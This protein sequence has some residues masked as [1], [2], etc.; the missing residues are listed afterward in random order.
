MR[1]ILASSFFGSAIEFYDFLLFATAA[2]VVFPTVFFPNT[3]PTVA[4]FASFGTLA[5][6]Y[7]ARPLGGV[8]FGH[9]GD[10]VG[11]K[12]VLVTSML[13]MGIAT[14]LMGVLPSSAQM[15]AFAPVLLIILR[16]VQGLAVGG[17]WGGAMLIALEHA[18]GGKRGLA[19]SFANLGA[20]AGAGLAALVIGV[21]GRLPDEQ[22]FS[23]GWR[24]PFLASLVLVAIG[25]IIRLKVAESP[26]FKQF[27]AEAERR[28]MPIVEVF[29]RHPKNLLLGVLVA[30]SQLTISGMSTVWAVN[31]AVSHGADRSGVL[32]SKAL[33]SLALF[34]AT[35]ISA[36]LS[37]RFGRK[38]ILVTGIAAATLFAYPM[39]LLVQSG[40]VASFT[41]AVMAGQAIQG[42][43]L[44]P[45]AAFLAELFPTAVRFTG[46]SLC[47][48]GASALGAGLTPV[49]ASALVTASGSVA[50][51][52][53]VWA[54]VLLLCLLAVVL[55]TEG[56]RRDLATMV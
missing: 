17:E 42:I 11:R 4:T 16:V 43:I 20:P 6:G 22:F 35:I 32:N 34:V 41:I 49:A 37:D 31:F 44:G 21:A 30:M 23:W 2:A 14:T 50:L 54:A 7:I 33:S 47:F 12:G 39:L 51:L 29:T 3:S 56:R 13:L 1:R 55:T 19:A 53:G 15:G 52:G 28:R 9:F 38:P 26:L 46:S 5:A 8:I 36:R 48:Q 25:L 45:L 27:E 10:R 18:P 40:T 24:I